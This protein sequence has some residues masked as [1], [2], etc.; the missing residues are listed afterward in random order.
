MRN[1]ILH[2]IYQHPSF[3]LI[4]NS[5]ERNISL[6][7]GELVFLKSYFALEQTRKINIFTTIF[8]ILIGLVG[9]F[10]TVFVFAQKRFRTNSNNVFLL[11]LAIND[12]LFLVIHLFEDTIRTYQEIYI[13]EENSINGT[14]E[15]KLAFDYLIKA[16][17]I[18][19]K[20]H[21]ACALVN[22]LRYS[23]RFI[24]AYII[25]VFTVQRLSVVIRPLK[26]TFKSKKSAWIAVTLI[27]GVAFLINA[28]VPFV[29]ELQTE[30][31]VPYCEIRKK[32]KTGY[33]LSTNVYIFIIL[34]VPM[35]TIFV[36]NL[37][38]IISAKKTVK[39]D[40][41]RK[42]YHKNKPDMTGCA[43]QTSNSHSNL[44]AFTQLN[45][46][47]THVFKSKLA[48]QLNRNKFPSII[49]NTSV[50]LLSNK[51]KNETYPVPVRKKALSVTKFS[52]KFKPLYK[53]VSQLTSEGHVNMSNSNKITTMLV[54]VSMS[55]AILNL[56]Y[57]VTWFLFFNEFAVHEN[58]NDSV[59]QNYLFAAVQI[60]EIFYILNFSLHFYFYCITSTKFIKQLKYSGK[61][62]L[63]LFFKEYLLK[64]L[65]I[66]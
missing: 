52:F 62:V 55:Y 32:W 14:S 12:S 49:S 24:S 37:L 56:P 43:M 3:K 64:T 27:I 59:I 63:I 44:T 20:F 54:L 46:T 11:C 40:L 61:L 45:H 33:F 19:D 58:E 5:T 22:Y 2:E 47:K 26:K 39:P 1:R 41:L 15:L 51:K 42:H 57:L 10:L 9:N 38:I 48:A 13:Y 16:L 25:V 21:L 35:I 34:V 31:N 23:L 8:F 66:Y 36:S 65:I 18:T 28:W 30:D 4:E 6:Y 7:D 29:F 60:S 50:N 53:N 17:N